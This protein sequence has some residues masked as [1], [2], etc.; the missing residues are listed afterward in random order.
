MIQLLKL[1]TII[2]NLNIGMQEEEKK[3]QTGTRTTKMI[4]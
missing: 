2:I 3:D 1:H 4:L